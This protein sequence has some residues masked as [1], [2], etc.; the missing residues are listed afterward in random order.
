MKQLT[1]RQAEIL[2]FIRDTLDLTGMPPTRS[3]IAEHFGFS[4]TFAV[5]KHLQ[6]LAKKQAIELLP[7]LSR[8]I[9]L[10]AEEQEQISGT[11]I[12][13]RVA[14]GNPILAEEYI[15]DYFEVDPRLFQPQADYLLRVHGMSMKDAGILDGDLVAVHKTLEARNGQIIV[16]RLDGE[17][18]VKRFL[19]TPENIQLLPENADFQPIVVDGSNEDFC[20]EGLVVGSIRRGHLA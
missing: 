20:I 10:P 6:A 16:A 18:T 15:E 3:E 19:R 9:R 5:G 14:A 8:G 2:Q 7:G 1:A 17:V 12:V 4:S 11:P 13:G